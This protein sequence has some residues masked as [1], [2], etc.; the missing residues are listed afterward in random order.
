M[1]GVVVDGSLPSVEAGKAETSLGLGVLG[2][3]GELG[4]FGGGRGPSVLWWLDVGVL[5]LDAA[6]ELETGLKLDLG[7]E[8]GVAF[9]SG[10]GAWLALEMAVD[11]EIFAAEAEESVAACCWYTF[12]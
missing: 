5:E 6:V 8:F 3:L 10:I 4:A 7:T 11:K 9:D 1:Q 2:T 12:R